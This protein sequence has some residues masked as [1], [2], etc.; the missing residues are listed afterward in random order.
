MLAEWEHIS[1]KDRLVYLTFDSDYRHN[2]HVYNAL[3][4]FKRWL[5]SKGVT[6]KI[7]S[8][9]C[10]D[11]GKKMGLDDFIADRLQKGFSN[12]EIR[13]ELVGLALDELPSFTGIIAAEV[14]YR[15]TNG[16]IEQIKETTN[17]ISLVQLTNFAARIVKETALD[18]GTGVSRRIFTVEAEFEGR[19][20][21][22]EVPATEFPSMRWVLQHI[23][24]GAVV[25]PNREEHAEV[26]IRM[27]S[28]QA[29]EV[30]YVEAYEHTGWRQISGV[31]HYLHAG[32]AISDAGLDKSVS[33]RLNGRPSLY[34][35]PEPQT[36]ERLIEAVRAS[37]RMREVI[38]PEA[39]LSLLAA[40]YRAVLGESDFSLYFTGESGAGKS[41]LAAL[42]QQHFGMKF[43][44]KSL[45]AAWSSTANAL[46]AEAF[47]I[48]DGII[49]V[50]DFVPRGSSIEIQRLQDKAERLLRG[51]GNQSGRGR[52]WAD[53]TN[54]PEKYPRGIIISTGEDL[55]KGQSLRARLLATEIGRTENDGN[56]MDWQRLSQAQADAGAGLYA[57]ALASYLQWLSGRFD[58][59]QKE[60]VELLPQLRE[61]AAS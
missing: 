58:D 54:R 55:P 34:D 31:W 26:A 56:V 2:R 24:S 51:Q 6:V 50:D 16:Y 33:L 45:P 30:E 53:G 27:L 49:T 23:G 42:A 14:P 1:L 17:G 38:N 3:A 18:D 47:T 29:G 35:L 48:K 20:R 13:Q 46:E 41:E 5:E 8:L 28:H 61:L 43:T 25:Y 40:V 32:G 60:R 11:D 59:V 37:L 12:E 19:T 4:R 52:L 44:G 22:F 7:I 36:E 39:S 21:C 15:I 9:P 10:A 57:E